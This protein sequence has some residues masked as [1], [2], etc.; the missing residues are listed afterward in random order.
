MPSTSI[1]TASGT[2]GMAVV[3]KK[4]AR[5]LPVVAGG[6]AEV[7]VAQSGLLQGATAKDRHN[8]LRA[9]SIASRLS[10]RQMYALL[11]TVT[12]DGVDRDR[13]RSS[14]H[15]AASISRNEVSSSGPEDEQTSSGESVSTNAQSTPMVGDSIEPPSFEER[16]RAWKGRN[17][18][19]AYATQRQEFFELPIFST[20]HAHV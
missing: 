13:H 4:K 18:N 2:T 7:C 12:E 8:A 19:A 11:S 16:Y 5:V 10:R 1:G 20:W 14:E 15:R 6:S 9:D 17:R 3:G